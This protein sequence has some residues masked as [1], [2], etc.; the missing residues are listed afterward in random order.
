MTKIPATGFV[1]QI[2]F[3]IPSFGFRHFN[4]R[5][6]N[7]VCVFC[8]FIAKH[9]REINV[10]QNDHIGVVF[11]VVVVLPPFIPPAETDTPGHRFGEEIV[12]RHFAHSAAST[13][14]FVQIATELGNDD[15]LARRNFHETRMASR[16]LNA[17]LSVPSG[18]VGVVGP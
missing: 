11:F 9:A 6:L 4:W 1:I 13:C 5:F 2:S 17:K 10:V 18:V 12:E 7:F 3:V 14:R 16:I 8:K 15:R